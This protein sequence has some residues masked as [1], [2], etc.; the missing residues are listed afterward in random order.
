MRLENPDQLRLRAAQGYVELGMFD[1]ANAELEEIDPFCRHLPDVLAMRVAI[2][3]GL[4]RWELMAIVAKKL[5]GWN[6]GDPSHFV[7][8]AYATRR[9]DSIHAAHTIL[10]RAAGLH[11]T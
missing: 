9:G 3:H 11:A 5:V 7:N 4:Q 1:T 8:L 6:P 10:T 2:Y